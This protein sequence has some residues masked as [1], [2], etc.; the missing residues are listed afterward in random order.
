MA[1]TGT[2]SNEV[3][4]DDMFVEQ[5][6]QAGAAP[7]FDLLGVHAPGYK[8]P[9]EMSPDEVAQK[10]EYGGQRFF[11]FRHVE[12][13]R[14]IMEKHGDGDKQIADPG[15]G[16]DDRSDPS[17]VCLARRHGSNSK[18]I[19]WCALINTPTNIGRPGLA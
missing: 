1:T 15:N 12:D 13:I 9:P 14:R 4:P 8:A 19:I 10:P 16:L 3:M 18:P 2:H 6:Y 11:A 7:Y 5:M 17:R